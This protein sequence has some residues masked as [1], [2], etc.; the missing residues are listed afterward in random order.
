M[1]HDAF[2]FSALPHT[3]GQLEEAWHQEELPASARTVVSVL[4]AMRGVGGINSWGA[5]VQPPW[6]VSA[7]QDHVLT[8]RLRPGR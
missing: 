6:R 2:A 4:G 1:E 5:D 3:P 7:E 8:F